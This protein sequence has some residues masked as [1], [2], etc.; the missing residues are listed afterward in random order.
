MEKP[1]TKKELFESF[2][3]LMDAEHGD[4]EELL[5]DILKEIGYEVH[6]ENGLY[7]VL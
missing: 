5:C 2:G 6:E 4:D 3:F 7:Y 1:Y